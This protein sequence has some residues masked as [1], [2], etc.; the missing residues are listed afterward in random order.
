M[1][2][3]TRRLI[4][5]RRVFFV[6]VVVV[7]VLV[8]VDKVVVGVAAV[9]VAIAVAVAVEGGTTAGEEAPPSADRKILATS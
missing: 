4:S 7:V 3:V 8:S 6:G 9:A 2:R 5:R 1:L